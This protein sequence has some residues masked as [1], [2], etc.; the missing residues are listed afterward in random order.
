VNGETTS[1]VCLDGLEL[2]RER[3]ELLER[4]LAHYR[5]QSR[6]PERLFNAMD[7]NRL[8]LEEWKVLG[9]PA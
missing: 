8:A 2:Y 7:K 4:L 1:A 6:P 5:T 3:A 9:F